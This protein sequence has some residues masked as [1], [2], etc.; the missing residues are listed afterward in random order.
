M[1]F[2][3]KDLVIIGFVGDGVSIWPTSCAGRSIATCLLASAVA[4]EAVDLGSPLSVLKD[5][6]R[7]AL[8]S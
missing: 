4:A 8:A 2:N 6:L 3:S 7:Q 1:A 5:Q